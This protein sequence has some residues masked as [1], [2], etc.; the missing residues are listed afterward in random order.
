MNYDLHEKANDLANL[1][2]DMQRRIENLKLIT[3][4][5]DLLE[6]LKAK[7]LNRIDTC[8]RGL[9]RIEQAYI[10]VLTEILAV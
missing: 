3:N 2:F 8:K 5:L 4:S 7:H 9:E 1:H 10:K 6:D